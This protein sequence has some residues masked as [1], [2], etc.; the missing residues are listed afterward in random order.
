LNYARNLGPTIA[1]G[2]AGSRRASVIDEERG[3]VSAR[4]KGNDLGSSIESSRDI[5]ER[6]LSA[7]SNVPAFLD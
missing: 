1:N 3:T 4:P 6:T 2:A 5:L 7:L